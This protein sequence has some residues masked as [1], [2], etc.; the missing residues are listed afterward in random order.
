MEGDLGWGPSW[1]S[2]RIQRCRSLNLPPA[3]GGGGG[4]TKRFKNGEGRKAW[5]GEDN[6][7]RDSSVIE[8]EHRSKP[9]KPKKPEEDIGSG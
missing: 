9:S 5:G 4:S 6:T 2:G 1:G 3:Y 7:I 8:G